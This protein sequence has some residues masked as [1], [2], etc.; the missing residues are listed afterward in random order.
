MMNRDERLLFGLLWAV[1]GASLLLLISVAG[2]AT[3]AD[4]MRGSFSFDRFFLVFGRL[5]S[6]ISFCLVGFLH[7]YLAY[8]DDS[9]HHRVPDCGEVQDSECLVLSCMRHIDRHCSDAGVCLGRRDISHPRL[10]WTLDQRCAVGCRMWRFRRL[11]LLVEGRPLV[12]RGA[13]EFRHRSSPTEFVGRSETHRGVGPAVNRA[14]QPRMGQ[15][16]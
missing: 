12:R 13:D 11:A 6:R 7:V 5:F 10:L 4:L 9:C 15:A 8:S 2:I 16:G 1:A 3:I 14:A